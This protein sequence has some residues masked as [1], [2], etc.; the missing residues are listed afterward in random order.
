MID[1]YLL[2][3]LDGTGKLFETFEARRPN[4]ANPIAV[5]YEREPDNSYPYL[6]EYASSQ[7]DSEKHRIIV[8]ES[9]SGPIAV[10]LAYENSENLLGLVLSASFISTPSVLSRIPVPKAMLQAAIAIAP[11]RFLAETLLLNGCP[12]RALLEKVIAVTQSLDPNVI[13]ERVAAARGADVSVA[14]SAVECPVLYLQGRHDRVVPPSAAEE[15]LSLNGRAEI[16]E[17]DSPHMVLQ[18]RPD[19]S[20]EAITRLHERYS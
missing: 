10:N 20:W 7:I 2:P 12:D 17:L 6:T 1:V 8:G 13:A 4:W 19:E 11:H 9:F 14:M 15:V 5:S 18:C 3:G 16:S